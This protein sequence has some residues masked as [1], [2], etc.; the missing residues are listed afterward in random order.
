[1]IVRP[2]NPISIPYEDS[3]FQPFI[4][5]INA[6]D[7]EPSPLSIGDADRFPSYNTNSLSSGDTIIGDRSFLLESL[8]SPLLVSPP[9]WTEPPSLAFFDIPIENEK[10]VALVCNFIH[11]IISDRIFPSFP[12]PNSVKPKPSCHCCQRAQSCLSIPI[13]HSTLPFTSCDLDSDL[14]SCMALFSSVF[15]VRRSELVHALMLLR[16]LFERHET[17]PLFSMLASQ[18]ILL[19]IVCMVLAHKT[20]TDTPIRT[21]KWAQAFDIEPRMLTLLEYACLDLLDW[22]ITLTPPLFEEICNTLHLL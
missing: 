18:P 2:I 5:E 13:P 22:R 17:C 1:M 11:G 10:T 15:N 4:V 20:S 8:G 21:R 9:P 12:T 16:K 19:F 6:I 14:A 3:S 7:T